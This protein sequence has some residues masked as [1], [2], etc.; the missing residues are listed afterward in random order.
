M[1]TKHLN[2][3]VSLC[4]IVIGVTILQIG[5]TLEKMPSLEKLKTSGFFSLPGVQKSIQNINQNII[6]I[7]NTVAEIAFYMQGCGIAV[8]ALGSIYLVILI[9]ASMREKRTGR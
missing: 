9:I 1:N 3:L 5:I 2:W 8:T 7:D 4:I 6:A